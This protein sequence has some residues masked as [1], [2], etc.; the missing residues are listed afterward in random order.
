MF[1]AAVVS[2]SGDLSHENVPFFEKSDY[3]RLGITPYLNDQTCVFEADGKIIQTHQYNINLI[4]LDSRARTSNTPVELIIIINEMKYDNSYII[5]KEDWEKQGIPIIFKEHENL[6][7]QFVWSNYSGTYI[8][9]NYNVLNITNPKPKKSVQAQQVPTKQKEL[10][11][12]INSI[13][14]KKKG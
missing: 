5:P 13:A 1:K 3:E 9:L 10:T 6:T 4:K 14:F 11:I 2:L 12:P 8:A 7:S